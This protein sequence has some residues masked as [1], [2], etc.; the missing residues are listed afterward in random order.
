MRPTPGGELG[1]AIRERF[2]LT[3]QL[4]PRYEVIAYAMA[5]ELKEGTDLHRGLNRS[6]VLESAKYWWDE[7]FR[8]RESAFKLLLQEMEGLGVLRAVEPGRYTL[9]NP[10]ILLL[11]GD[12][13]GS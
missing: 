11:L 9:R 1:D 6:R 2:L 8:L 5:H 10:N 13:E 7:G 3:L 12:V 4:D